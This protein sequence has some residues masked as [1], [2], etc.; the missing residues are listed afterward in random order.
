MRKK[1]N[2]EKDFIKGNTIYTKRQKELDDDYKWYY[3][4]FIAFILY[5]IIAVI[6]YLIH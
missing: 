5:D 6:R 2:L 3:L 4:F 1:S